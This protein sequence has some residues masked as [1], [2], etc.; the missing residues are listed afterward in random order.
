M[1][2]IFGKKSSG[3]KP[4]PSTFRQEK[5]A[6]AKKPTPIPSKIASQRVVLARQSAQEYRNRSAASSARSSPAARS[7]TGDRGSRPPTNK[8]KALQQRLEDDG[9]I[10]DGRPIDYDT[11]NSKR[12]QKDR[13]I[14]RQRRFLA[15][16]VLTPPDGQPFTFIHAADT[17]LAVDKLDEVKGAAMNDDVVSVE[18]RYPTASPLERYVPLRNPDF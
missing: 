14:D 8:R 16:S 4:R 5:V 2:S 1:N 18:L 7:E 11:Y 3:I 15:Q 6:V 10:D 17:V 9:E 13:A 12:H